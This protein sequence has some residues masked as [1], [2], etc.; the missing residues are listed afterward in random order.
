M[1]ENHDHELIL[2][3]R[4]KKD[5]REHVHQ[6]PA[7]G[8]MTIHS[9]SDEYKFCKCDAAHEGHIRNEIKVDKHGSETIEVQKKIFVLGGITNEC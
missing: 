6:C 1:S 8:G 3:E 9:L 2:A 4:Y 7:W 5:G